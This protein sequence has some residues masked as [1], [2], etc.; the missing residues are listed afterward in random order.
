MAYPTTLYTEF[1][2]ITNSAS[3]KTGMLPASSL[4]ASASAAASVFRCHL[5]CNRLCGYTTE[6]VFVSPLLCGLVASLNESYARCV[7]CNVSAPV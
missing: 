6:I 1:S 5:F 3:L 2:G 4:L 7:C